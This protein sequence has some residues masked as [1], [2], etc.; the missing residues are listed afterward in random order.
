MSHHSTT[1]TTNQPDID[2]MFAE[3]PSLGQLLSVL[4]ILLAALCAQTTQAA[5]P[6]K[7]W[8]DRPAQLWTEAL[9]IGNG[10][11]GG[12]V[13]TIRPRGLFRRSAWP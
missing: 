6:H 10:R 1:P 8:Y 12:M 4:L 2:M 13:R 9:P 7:L 5:G 3:K 11:L